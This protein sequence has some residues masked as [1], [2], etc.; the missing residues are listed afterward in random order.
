MYVV[1][2]NVWGVCGLCVVCVWG[3]VCVA[4]CVSCECVL[5]ASVWASVWGVCVAVCCLCLGC[6]WLGG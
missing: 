3:G 1:W 5:W 6:V 2:A 4:V